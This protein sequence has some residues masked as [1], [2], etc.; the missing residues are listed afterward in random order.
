MEAIL[1]NSPLGKV[2]LEKIKP[3][4]HTSSMS[5][6]MRVLML[7]EFG[8]A[9]LDTDTISK[10]SIPTDIPNFAMHGK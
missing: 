9:Y 3:I 4:G 6:L 10:D 1:I 5:N 2:W 8:G 7:F